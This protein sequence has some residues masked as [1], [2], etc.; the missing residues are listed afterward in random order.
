V[1]AALAALRIGVKILLTGAG[2]FIGRHLGRELAERHELIAL[3]R[4]RGSS[5]AWVS[6]EVVHDLL[7]PLG[8]GRLPDRV[9]AVIHLAQSE[10]YRAFPEHADD[11][12]AINVVATHHLLE[13]ARAARAAAF[14]YTSTGGVYGTSYER[15]VESDPVNPLN[16]YFSSKY[17]AELMIGNY[18]RFFPTIVLRPFFV[19]GPGQADRMLIPRLIHR[20][21]AGETVTVDGNPGIRINPLFVTDAIRVFEPALELRDSGLFNIAGDEIVTMTELVRKI[22]EAAATNPV[23]EHVPATGDGDLV[24]DTSR[25]RDVLG[26][27]PRVTLQDGLRET[28]RSAGQSVA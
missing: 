4:R 19:Y 10:H 15:F 8:R 14:V 22:A 1:R 18:R 9:D 20:V 17:S 7:E 24:G 16:F 12:L 23:I 21:L 25:M 27:L 13:Y 28:V 5:G 6:E 26:V 3:V 2:G 11:V